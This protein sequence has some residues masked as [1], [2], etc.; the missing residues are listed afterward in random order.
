MMEP[1]VDVYING[2]G[3][4]V[5]SGPVGIIGVVT[6]PPLVLAIIVTP[7]TTTSTTLIH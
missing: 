4:I 3:I 2:V 1:V 5:K 7:V 6:S